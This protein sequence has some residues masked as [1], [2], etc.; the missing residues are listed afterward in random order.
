MNIR[1]IWFGDK[2]IS[3]IVFDY[4]RYFIVPAGVDPKYELV[5]NSLSWFPMFV[6]PGVSNGFRAECRYG[7]L[8]ELFIV[9]ESFEIIDAQTVR[10]VSD[11][12]IRTFPIL[13]FHIIQKDVQSGMVL[14]DVAVRIILRNTGLK[15]C[16]LMEVP[17]VVRGASDAGFGTDLETFPAAW[18][19][20]HGESKNTQFEVNPWVFVVSFEKVFC[21]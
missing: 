4:I 18:N 2:D 5:Q 6:P 8:G 15:C 12:K 13:L 11:G 19:N 7:R 14:P 20:R 10:Y 9:P 17:L 16:R 3:L 1:T 21:P